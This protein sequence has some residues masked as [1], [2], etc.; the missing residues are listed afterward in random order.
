MSNKHHYLTLGDLRQ[1]LLNLP[2]TPE[3]NRLPLI[4]SHDDE[5]N[6]YQ[7]V[8]WLPSVV[9]IVEMKAR[10]IERIDE[11]EMDLINKDGGIHAIIIN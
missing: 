8:N 9:T 5:G 10:D 6:E 3:F 11:D 4:Y 7:A 1:A 2:D